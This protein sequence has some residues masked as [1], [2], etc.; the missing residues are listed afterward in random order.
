MIL[1]W[2]RLPIPNFPLRIPH[3]SVIVLVPIF[4]KLSTCQIIEESLKLHSTTMG[5]GDK[6]HYQPLKWASSDTSLDAEEDGIS[7]P[8]RSP[9]YQRLCHCHIPLLYITNFVLVVAIVFQKSRIEGC[10]STYPRLYCTMNKR[11]Y[12]QIRRAAD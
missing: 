2:N 9:L 1:C 5:F 6:I 8:C 4:Q 3:S 12:Y 10:A 7:L 11:L